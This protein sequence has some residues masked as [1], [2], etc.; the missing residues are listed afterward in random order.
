LSH[1][2]LAANLTNLDQMQEARS[3]VGAGLSLDPEFTVSG[4]ASNDWSDNPV[5]L[6]RRVRIIDG[7]RQAGVPEG[8][9]AA[10]PIALG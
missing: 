5:Y 6:A 4:F 10:T 8:G 1:F 3:E 2:V 7:M 9:A